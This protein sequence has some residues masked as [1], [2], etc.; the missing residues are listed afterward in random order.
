MYVNV[1]IIGLSKNAKEIL[2]AA[3][4]TKIVKVSFD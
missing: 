1:Y 4:M 2:Q 3:N